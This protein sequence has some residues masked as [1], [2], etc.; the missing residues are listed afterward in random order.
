MRTLGIFF[1]LLLAITRSNPAIAREDAQKANAQAMAQNAEAERYFNG[2]GVA[3]DK[4]RA[5]A[6]FE[7][8]CEGGIASS[9]ANLGWSHSRGNGVPK[10]I[11]LAAKYF[12]KAC[13]GDHAK[14]CMILGVI[15]VSGVGVPNDPK[16]AAGLLDKARSL[17]PDDPDIKAAISTLGKDLKL[18]V[19]AA[20]QSSGD[21]ALYAMDC[22]AGKSLG[23]YNLGWRYQSGKGVKKDKAKATEFYDKACELK[24][25]FAC[26]VLGVYYFNGDDVARDYELAAAYFSKA[27]DGNHSGGCY[28]LGDSYG[29]GLGVKMSRDQEFV[30]YRK[31]LKLNPENKIVLNLLKQRIAVA[32]KTNKDCG[33]GIALECY[34]MGLMFLSGDGVELNK[35]RSAYFF[36][37]ACDLNVANGCFNLG[38]LKFN[39]DVPGTTMEIFELYQRTLKIDPGHVEA[40]KAMEK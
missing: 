30:L 3:V 16:K 9:C 37:K 12:E 31:A 40:R 17:D 24:D 27:C 29:K 21:V 14:S 18:K 34:N 26:N 1:L 5:I 19:N 8:A 38:A 13:D 6:L 22:K 39:G 7:Q 28:N 35:L 36:G 33:N 20:E 25:A 32:E 11:P 4:A 23:C 10:N 2:T 15:I